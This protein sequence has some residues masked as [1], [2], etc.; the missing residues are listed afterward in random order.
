VG[1]NIKELRVGVS[2]FSK[3]I[4][5]FKSPTKA[6]LCLFGGERIICDL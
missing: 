4:L 1:K 3:V 6:V 2:L 5:K